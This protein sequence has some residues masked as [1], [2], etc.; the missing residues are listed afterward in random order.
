MVFMYVYVFV[1]LLT[2]GRIDCIDA[3]AEVD[4]PLCCLAGP[5]GIPGVPGI[6]G[7]P[8]R[9]GLKGDKG[10]CAESGGAAKPGPVTVPTVNI[11][12]CAWNNLNDG[13][14][15]VII[16]DCI[17]DKKSEDT[18][19]RVTWNGNLRSLSS[20]GSC[21]RW[22]FT[23][24]GVECLKPFAIDSVIHTHTGVNIHRSTSVEGICFGIPAG[25]V[26][27]EF[28][29]GTC[30]TGHAMGDA[31]TGWAS[32]SRVIVEEIAMSEN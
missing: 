23:F 30:S 31:Y 18:A 15:N 22:Y 7:S 10:E 19:I 12:Q 11:K 1:L 5:A 32:V 28:R 27:V 3:V 21:V 17:F 6:P 29:V 4:E 8:G 2:L 9:D 24:D 14:E 16:K 13:R 20:S 25:R 26:D